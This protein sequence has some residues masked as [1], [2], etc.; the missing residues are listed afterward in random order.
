MLVNLNSALKL[1][2]VTLHQ[3]SPFPHSNAASSLSEGRT[4]EKASIKL[5]NDPFLR[6]F[7]LSINDKL[8]DWLPVRT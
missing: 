5:S 4:Q 3:G 6:G 1:G 8:K 7:T 2:I